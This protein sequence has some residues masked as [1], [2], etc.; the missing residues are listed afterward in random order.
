MKKLYSIKDT[1]TGLWTEPAVMNNDGEAMRAFKALTKDKNT[2]I[3]AHPEDYELHQI[4]EWNPEQ[5]TIQNVCNNFLMSGQKP[6]E[7]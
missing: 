1:V 6:V 5:G 3:G 2:M 7:E 4:G